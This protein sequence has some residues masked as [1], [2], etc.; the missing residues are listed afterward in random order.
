[1]T[2]RPMIHVIEPGMLTT[3]QGDGRYGF[4]EIGVVAGG[5]ADMLS[6]K[7]GNRLLSNESR[8]AA[9]EMTLVGGTFEFTHDTA[10]VV[11]GGATTV[12]VEGQSTREL[13]AWTPSVIS[14]GGRLSIGPLQAGARAYLCVAGGIDV[15]VVMNSRSTNLAAGFGGLDGRA[16]RAGDWLPIG[17]GDRCR[18]VE[19]TKT[20]AT[21]SAQ[22]KSKTRPTSGAQPLSNAQPLASEEISQRAQ[23]SNAFKTH[24]PPS[25]NRTN[26]LRSYCV[27]FVSRRVLRAVDGP[28]QNLFIDD[29]VR[30]F[31]NL[32]FEIS[33]QSNR[34]GLRLE[35]L[36]RGTGQRAQGHNDDS[37]Q[38]LEGTSNDIG[39]RLDRQSPKN[40]KQL[41]RHTLG[42]SGAVGK[43]PSEGMMHGA[44]QV[45]E[46]GQPIVL[47]VD[48]PTTGGYPV[49]ATVA[50][51]DHPVLGQL[52]PR[53]QVSFERVSR[54]EAR[55][56]YQEQQAAIEQIWQSA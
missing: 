49:I 47:M 23:S 40:R 20:R 34:T 25:E 13:K 1:M 46:D 52:R 10:V 41:V 36:S 29:A 16:L 33:N 38:Q 19:K 4:A 50:T 17:A 42:R 14:A 18:D 51:V 11:T 24:Q 9:L 3:V 28:H 55:R 43:L 44:V 15:P 22:Q 21:S 48:H 37:G 12:I 6:Y 27:D 7:V 39:Q 45:P 53:E 32:K 8:A 56:L 54:D 31:W 30:D 35:V 26:R 2:D 5:A